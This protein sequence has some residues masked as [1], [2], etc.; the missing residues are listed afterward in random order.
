[1]LVAALIAGVTTSQA[2]TL[3]ALSQESVAA[4]TVSTPPLCPAG[5]VTVTGQVGYRGT[6]YEI[7]QLT[8]TGIPAN[9][10]GKAFIAQFASPG[11]NT[12]LGST[13]GTLPNTANGTVAVP[14][15]SGPSLDALSSTLKVV[16][17]VTG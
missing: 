14:T 13:T 2:A 11:T 16:L 1:M 9:C 17:Y 4:G 15:G 6:R 8:F 5:A 12:S 10:Q 3:G 7:Y